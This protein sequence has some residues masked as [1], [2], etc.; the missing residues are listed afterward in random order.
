MIEAE[1]KAR[2]SNPGPVRAKLRELAGEPEKAI[3]HDAYYDTADRGLETADREL[4][5]RTV[6]TPDTVR[7]LLTFK[8][9]A[10][11]EESESKPEYETALGNPAAVVRLFEA[12]GYGVSVG[13]TK[14]CENYRLA[15]DGRDFLATVARVPELDDT[16]LEVETIAEEA[17]VDRALAAVRVMLGHLG[18][19][20]SDLTT[21][22][23][24][25]A[26]RAARHR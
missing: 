4:R 12:L 13:L 9:P 25:D 26:V 24:T 21:E 20:D 23:Y 16:Y 15:Q 7:H 3:Y 11:D 8:D 6:E 19:P 17:D 18:V 10:V 5:L 1:L 14:D 22:R 2:L